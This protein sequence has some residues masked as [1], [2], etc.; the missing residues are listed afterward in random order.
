M[1]AEI[2]ELVRQW[3]D[4]QAAYIADREKRFDAILDVLELQYAHT[5][6]T[7]VDLACG[8]G[9]LSA[10]ILEKFK[11]ASV[12]GI[13]YD[14]MLLEVARQSSTRFGDRLQ[15]VDADLLSTDWPTSV[16]APVQAIVS[17]TALH[18]LQPQQ[19]VEVYRQCR[20][21][22][23]PDGVL[24]NGDH[25]RFDSR[26]P[27]IGRWAKAHD[28]QTQRSAFAAGAPEWDSWWE[29]LRATPGIGPLTDERE[30]RFAGRDATAPTAVDFQLAALAQAGFRESGT[31]WQLFDDYVVYGVR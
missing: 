23:S 16:T 4:Q 30:R 29:E 12:V 7:V 20:E 11:H 1:S 6:F 28:E 14:P 24:L 18:W 3:D 17:T 5:P 26:F 27:V 22:L 25:F 8:P 9:S 10:R 2:S 15:L 31:V 13:D 19:L 21:L